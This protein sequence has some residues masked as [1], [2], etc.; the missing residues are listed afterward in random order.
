MSQK[1]WEIV[2]EEDP[3]NGDLILPLPEDFL[4]QVG[5]KEG[6]ELEWIDNGDGTWQIAKIINPDS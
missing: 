2:V 4:K 5:W 3:E 6:D 1:N